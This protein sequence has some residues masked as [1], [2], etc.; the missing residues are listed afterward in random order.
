MNA[1]IFFSVQAIKINYLVYFWEP[2]KLLL[3]SRICWLG[4]AL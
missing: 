4:L 2:E 1:D 3:K